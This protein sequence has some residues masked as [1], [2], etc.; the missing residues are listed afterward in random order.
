MVQKEYLLQGLGCAN[1][2]AKIETAVGKLNGVR[3][4][5]VSF[6]TAVLRIEFEE[7]F[8]GDILP[9]IQ[10]IVHSIESHVVVTEK[11]KR[12]AQASQTLKTLT[13]PGPENKCTEACCTDASESKASDQTETF[14]SQKTDGLNRPKTYFEGTDK[15]KLLR[16]LIGA[17][18]YLI[19][20]LLH[21]S[22]SYAV[23]I[24]SATGTPHAAPIEFIIFIAAYVLI[25]GDVLYKAAQSVWRREFFDESILMTIA[26]VGAFLIA[27]FP[28]AVAVML[29]YQVGE[30]FQEIAVNKSRRSIQSMMDIRPDS[31]HR[32]RKGSD[33]GNEGYETVSP[34]DVSVGDIILVKPGEKIPLDG[35]V[36][37]GI[38]LVDTSS[39]TGEFVPRN[40]KAGDAVLSG[41]INKSGTLTVRVDHSFEESTV[42]KILDLIENAAA[43][44]APTEKFITKFS[45][46]YTPAVIL[47]AALVAFLP[48]LFLPEATFEEWIYRGLVFLVISCPCALVI[49]VPLSY[50]GGIGAASK[51][52]VLVKGG[53]YLEGL[54]QVKTVVF[55]KTGTLSKGVFE[56]VRIDRPED[57]DMSESELLTYSAAAESFSNHPIAL[58]I[59]KAAES[60]AGFVLNPAA[61]SAHSE[62]SGLGVK[63][64]YAEKTLL[65]GNLKWMKQEHIPVPDMSAFD[66]RMRDAETHIYAAVDGRFAGRIILSDEIK[67]DS[68]EALARLKRLGIEQTVMVTGD[69]DRVGRAFAADLGLDAVYTEQLPHQ[70]VEALEKI[71][72]ET[73]AAYPKSKVAFVGDG[74]NDAPALTR[75]DIGIAVG[76]VGSDAAVEAADIVLMTG[77][78]TQLADAFEVAKKTK[79]VVYQNIF[80]ALG[81]KLLFMALG[82]FGIA[83]MWE[84]VFADVGVTVLAVLNSMRLLR[85]K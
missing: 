14:S 69:T 39:L 37:S 24:F 51:K 18:I 1:C 53:N 27:D 21:L 2:A 70:K 78:P 13:R 34:Y 22:H 42:S 43:K 72:A 74:I 67:P 59:V 15:K 55:D 65:L 32:Q 8:Q 48:P 71:E 57:S 19:G 12:T 30:F 38:S 11:K 68:K 3:E 40:A 81:I 4:A 63:A 23:P 56:V 80:F 46:Y 47:A 60:R 85:G 5:S 6:A 36:L 50:F 73:K 31:A 45:R 84:A 83:S 54:T 16:I 64:V 9:D 17:F 35:T 28:E 49:S 82:L 62:F 66:S 75:A 44:K 77:D 79:S 25:G 58:S 10:K 52:G 20:I 33:G 61:V 26:T 7:D 29:F 41:S 76:G